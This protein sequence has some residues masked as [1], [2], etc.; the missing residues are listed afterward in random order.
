MPGPGCLATPCIG[1]PQ[2]GEITPGLWLL[3]GLRQPR[4]QHHRDRRRDR[5]AR[6]RRGRSHLAA[7]LAVRAGVV[8]RAFRPGG[9]AGSLLV[10]AHA[11]AVRRPDGAAPRG[12]APARSRRTEQCERRPKRLRPA[13]AGTGACPRTGRVARRRGGCAGDGQT[14]ARCRR[15]GEDGAG[16]AGRAPRTSSPNPNGPGARRRTKPIPRARGRRRAAPAEPDAPCPLSS[17]GRSEAPRMKKAGHAQRSGRATASNAR[18]RPPDSA[19]LGDAP[20]GPERAGRLPDE[21]TDRQRVRAAP[22]IGRF[23]GPLVAP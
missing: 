12:A 17:N 22:C 20:D 19:E 1:M 8:R 10:L 6:H 14:A 2:I 7:V 16:R 15:G 13:D 23:S 21:K 3:V 18:W 11:R 9:A 5:G 4:A